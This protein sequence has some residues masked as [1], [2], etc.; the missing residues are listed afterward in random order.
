MRFNKHSDFDG[1]HALLSPSSYH[2]INYDDQKL[3]A[4]YHS[5]R[6]SR[7][8]VRKHELARL[9]IELGVRLPRSPSSINAYV[10]DGIRFGMATEQMLFYS[11][12]C[13]GTADAISFKKRVL[14]IHD[15][16]TGITQTSR[17]Q[18]DVYA[19]LFCLEYGVDP[20]NI[21][22]VL[23][24][25]QLDGFV[26]YDTEPDH[27]SRIMDKIVDF[28]AKIEAMRAEEFGSEEE[29]TF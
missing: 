11:R 1:Q 12:N 29:N 25:Y 14:R 20:Y 5:S 13:F 15:L 28:D 3:K 16:K 27:I 2:W 8:G 26:E 19:A 23:R 17:Y 24:I 7:I 9:A 18:L 10:N 6:A 4:K 21:D 22:F